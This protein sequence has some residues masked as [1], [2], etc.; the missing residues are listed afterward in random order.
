VQL[1]LPNLSQPLKLWE[2][3]EIVVGK[4]DKA[5]FYSSR[6]EDF[7]AEGIVIS[8]PE[9][10][11][12]HTLLRE[13][14]EVEI[15]LTRDDAAYRCRS[16]VRKYPTA[17]KNFYLLASPGPIKRVQRRQFVRIEMLER[18][19][20]ARVGPVMDWEE[21][22]ER[23]RWIDTTTVDMSGG[24][25]AMKAE[26]DLDRLDRLFLRIG[27]FPR[28]GLPETVVG[29]VRRRFTSDKRRI[30][31]IEFIVSERLR[32]H[33]SVA[34]V[35]RLPAAATG[36]DRRAQNRLAN[37]IFQREIELRRKGLL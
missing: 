11:S 2:K 12:G 34:D 27:F 20:Y 36:F 5:G 25:L 24:G 17:Q 33:F 8:S 4:G 14:A 30:V 29:I 18:L 35:K 15:L 28:Q 31:G 9:Y 13:N 19:C 37:F 1:T 21:Y 32:D 22:A 10:V 6:I 23:L 7:V 3:L 26:S 16:R